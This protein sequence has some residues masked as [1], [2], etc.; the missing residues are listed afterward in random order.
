MLLMLELLGVGFGLLAATF[1]GIGDYA[2][3]L[4]S[5]RLITTWVVLIANGAGLVF[6]MAFAI[7]GSEPLPSLGTLGLGLLAGLSGGAGI[8]ALFRA[9]AIGHMGIASPVSAVLTAA[10]PVAFAAILEGLPQLIQ[11]LGF[12]LALLGVWIVSM[13][14]KGST[15][16]DGLSLA[17]LAGVGFAGF[18][19]LMAL[20]PEGSVFWP[21]VAARVGGFSLMALLVLK[22]GK[23]AGSVRSAFLLALISG[24]LDSSGNAMYV[25]STQA[26]RLDSA[27]VLSALYPAV[28]AFL[29]W[30]LL[31][32]KL[33]RTQVLGIVLMIVAIPLI[34]LG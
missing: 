1:W 17:I 11:Y 21:L 29:A 25:L 9:M 18:K 3:G 34:T 30:I 26:G 20:V 5:R 32:E 12:A 4:A 28:T 22:T 2:G 23:F 13:P 31:K 24:A 10:I 19:I 14:S 6:L 7:A 27:A 33:G 16:T 8:L 15:R